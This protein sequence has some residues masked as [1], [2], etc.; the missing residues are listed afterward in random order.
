M[1]ERPPD[2]LLPTGNFKQSRAMCGPAC[3]KIVFAYFGKRVPEKQIA[4]A[5]RTSP[6]SGTTGTNLVKGAKRFGFNAELIDY[7]NF[8]TIATWLRR[9]VPVIVD[10]MSTASSGPGHARIA[11]GHYSVVCGLGRDHIVL[12]DPAVGGRRRLSRTSF[13]SVWFDFKDV[14]P[15]TADDLIIRRVILVTQQGA[16]SWMSD[17][18]KT[19]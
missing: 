18:I 10:W 15:K 16:N 7:S 14:F 5:C 8:R 17:I 13:Q 12:Q 11:G 3:L 19:R 9:G 2:L 6:R 4:K 1:A